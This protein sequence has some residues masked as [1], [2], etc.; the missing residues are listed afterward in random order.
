MYMAMLITVLQALILWFAEDAFVK[1]YTDLPEVAGMI[2][3]A[4]PILIIFTIFDTTQAM[5]MSVI[6]AS[7]K[8]SSGA[9][10][11]G[12]AYFILGVPAS[13]YFAFEKDL[14]NRGLWVGPT[15]AVAFNTLA[16]NIIICFID[17]HKLIK[18][19][20]EREKQEDELRK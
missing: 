10:I 15:V 7:G 8:Q 3:V 18:E 1:M 20:K 4:W 19:L 17:W 14:N 9:I 12:I 2:R 11:T 5:A 13:Y 16:Y 6:K